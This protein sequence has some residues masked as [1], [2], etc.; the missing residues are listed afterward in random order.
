MTS[1][2]ELM[3]ELEGKIKNLIIEYDAKAQEED[4]V[5]DGVYAISLTGSKLSQ[6]DL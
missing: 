2:Q 5:A 6:E 1:N 4:V 3:K